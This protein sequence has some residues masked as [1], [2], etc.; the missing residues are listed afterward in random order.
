MGL[1]G[2]H[3]SNDTMFVKIERKKDVIMGECDSLII[4]LNKNKR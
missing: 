4:F 1:M 3:F 2:I